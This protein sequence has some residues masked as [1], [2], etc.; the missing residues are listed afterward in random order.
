MYRKSTVMKL[1]GRV[2]TV[3]GLWAA[4]TV[5]FA[6]ALVAVY[7]IDN[8]A[9]TENVSVSRE[10]LLAIDRTM[11]E[12]GHWY[13]FYRPDTFTDNLMLSLSYEPEHPGIDSVAYRAFYSEVRARSAMPEWGAEL[14]FPMA[15]P[16]HADEYV[17]SYPR[18][19]HG[20]QVVVRPLLTLVDYD[21]I[22]LVNTLLCVILG[23]WFICLIWHRLS[24]LTAVWI[25]V[26]VL[27]FM[28]VWVVPQC[29]QF[30]TC[31]LLM[32][33]TSIAVIK[34][35]VLTDSVFRTFC[36]FFTAGAVT[37]CLD[38]LTTPLLTLCVPLAFV[39]VT[40]PAAG[41]AL[42]RTVGA[43][44]GWG[45]GYGL[46]WF[47]K[48][49]IAGI[50]SGTDLIGDALRQAALRTGPHVGTPAM[51]MYMPLIITVLLVGLV[52]L[53]VA[54][55]ITYWR[56]GAL[57]PYTG[58]LLTAAL[59]LVWALALRNH[60]FYHHWFTWRQ[61]LV[62]VVCLGLYIQHYMKVNHRHE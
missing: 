22:R 38:F 39:I 25:A 37:V 5:V 2:L 21:G 32:F 57:R 59:P 55:F 44:V 43:W 41:T 34:Y 51:D 4:L 50:V 45:A 10:Q 46:L 30:A 9:L 16:P 11:E 56:G 6:G 49:V 20:Y 53:T 58:L 54:A 26:V 7:M 60:T 35:K 15:E 31:F 18:Y 14:R 28:G 33:L 62:T 3:V 42:T 13:D 1:T 27:V 24:P 8:R 23:G 29:M 52:A 48:W 19:W 40:Y 12:Q 61:G 17:Y 47:T 36:T